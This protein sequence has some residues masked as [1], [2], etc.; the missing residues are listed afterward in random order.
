MKCANDVF[1]I[2]CTFP[3]PRKRVLEGSVY[4]KVYIIVKSGSKSVYI[5]HS[6]KSV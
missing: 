6:I 2:Y 1:L 4:G 5:N 3:V